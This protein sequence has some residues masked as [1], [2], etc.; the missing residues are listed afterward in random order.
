MF[1]TPNSPRPPSIKERDAEI[2]ALQAAFDEYIASSRELEDELDAELA[3]MQD[4]LAESQAANSALMAQLE[5][6]NPQYAAMEQVLSETKLKLEAETKRSRDREMAQEELEAR[7]Q[8]IQLSLE[9][10]VS[11]CNAL[12]ERLSKKEDEMDEARIELEVLKE[13]YHID[14]EQLRMQLADSNSK[15][16]CDPT[17]SI[18]S[19]SVS[20]D[21]SVPKGAKN[22]IPFSPM[23]A[24]SRA[25]VDSC[26]A[27]VGETEKEDY[28]RRLEDEL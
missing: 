10:T 27:V 16:I 18:S 17:S 24:A 20:A 3:R 6:Q 5:A 13:K 7:N 14:L 28:V 15:V 26:D 22:E 9:H 8:G 4:R 11:K 19:M 2:A 12:Q 25:T 23:S 21:V 1:G